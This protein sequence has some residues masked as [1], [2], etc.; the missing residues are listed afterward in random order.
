VPD[1]DGKREKKGRLQRDR[2]HVERVEIKEAQQAAPV[3]QRVP[4]F[5]ISR[6]RGPAQGDHLG[7]VEDDREQGGNAAHA[8]EGFPVG[9]C[10]HSLSPKHPETGFFLVASISLASLY[11]RRPRSLARRTKNPGSY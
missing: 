7:Q 1:R 11:A 10:V 6:V 8:I 2:D 9:V 4:G 3:E 5:H